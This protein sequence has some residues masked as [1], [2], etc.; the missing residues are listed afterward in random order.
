[1]NAFIVEDSE[2][3]RERLIDTLSEKSNINI[4]GSTG[5]PTEAVIEISKLKPDVVILDMKLERGS[6]LDVLWSIRNRSGSPKIIVFTNYPF[7]R[8][9]CKEAGADYFF[10]KSMDIE[11]LIKTIDIIS[12]ATDAK[13]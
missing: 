2:I 9:V 8:N 5:N 3:I 12:T 6:G 11:E 4:L 7:Y 10:D 13:N 1:M